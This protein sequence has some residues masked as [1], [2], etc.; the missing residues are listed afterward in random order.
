MPT[1]NSKEFFSSIK[2]SMKENIN[3]QDFGYSKRIPSYIEL[4]IKKN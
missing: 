3:A 1:R 2:N 4:R